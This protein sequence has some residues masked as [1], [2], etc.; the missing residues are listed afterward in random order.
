MQPNPAGDVRPVED[1][2]D[3]GMDLAGRPFLTLG[4]AVD[5]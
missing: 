3:G 1:G 4:V 2:R 5:E